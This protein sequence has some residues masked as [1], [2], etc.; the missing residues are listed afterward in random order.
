MILSGTGCLRGS[1]GGG[2][3][4][5]VMLAAAFADSV[6]FAGG[7]VSVVDGCRDLR[8]FNSSADRQRA[9][10]RKKKERAQRR[11]AQRRNRR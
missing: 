7:P 10:K 2:Y 4:R 6:M 3:L 1:M 8:C 11:K 9:W 5:T